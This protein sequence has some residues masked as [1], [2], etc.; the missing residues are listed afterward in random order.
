MADLIRFKFGVPILILKLESSGREKVT[1]VAAD[2]LAACINR[3]STVL[4]LATQV[5]RPIHQG[6]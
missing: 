1:S 3:A 6:I 5:K 2:V 4:T